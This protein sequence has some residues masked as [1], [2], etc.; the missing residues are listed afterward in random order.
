MMFDR[1]SGCSGCAEAGSDEPKH[2]MDIQPEGW[3]I[4]DLNQGAIVLVDF[5]YS[6]QQRID[7]QVIRDP[8]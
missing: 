1:F 4:N 7:W 8:P 5:S 6:N 2:G 3:L